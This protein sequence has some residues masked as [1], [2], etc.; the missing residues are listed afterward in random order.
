MKEMFA[1][2]HGSVNVRD[3]DVSHGFASYSHRGEKSFP[4]RF[5][6]GSF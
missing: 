2:A 1:Q 3:H 6:G 4:S 5:P